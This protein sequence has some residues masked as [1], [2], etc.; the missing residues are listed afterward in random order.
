[1]KV[2]ES[3]KFL[4]VFMACISMLGSLLIPL[5]YFKSKKCR[6]HPSQIFFA[7]SICEC[8]SCYHLL[9]WACDTHEFIT[10]FSLDDI[11]Q[12][13]LLGYFILYE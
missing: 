8:L 1:M 13:Y 9:V 10:F 11:F 3:E 2:S 6:H 7:I 12:G 5:M 4:Y